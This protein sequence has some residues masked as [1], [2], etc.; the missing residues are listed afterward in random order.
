[1]ADKKYLQKLKN[2]ESVVQKSSVKWVLSNFYKTQGKH[3]V[4]S[5]CLPKMLVNTRNCDEDGLL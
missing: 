1:M 5:P 3:P 2:P 4:W